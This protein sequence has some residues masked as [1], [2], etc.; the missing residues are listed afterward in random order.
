LRQLGVTIPWI[1][2]PSIVTD[3]A[4]KLAGAALHGTYAVADF[5]ANSSAEA[6]S[7]AEKDRA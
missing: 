4:M 6:K 2:S 5:N 1:G 3:T 7:F